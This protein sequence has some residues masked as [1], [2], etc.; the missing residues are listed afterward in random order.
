MKTLAGMMKANVKKR[1]KT[2][3]KDQAPKMSKAAF[4]AKYRKH[5]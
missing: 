2:N 3:P 1:A 4:L 5:K